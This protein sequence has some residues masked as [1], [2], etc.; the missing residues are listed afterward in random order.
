M[1][2]GSFAR[3]LVVASLV[4]VAGCESLS[5]PA[6]PQV[7]TWLHHPGGALSVVYRRALTQPTRQVGEVYERGQP[8]YAAVVKG[9]GH[10]SFMDIPYLPVE[11]GSM[12]A[13]GL[14]TVRID[15]RRFWR[16]VSDYLLAF[17]GRHL[18]GEAAP[19]L[20]GPSAEHPE[21]VVGA[22]RAGLQA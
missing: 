18:R 1:K 14:A 19:L 11:P 4:P 6:T 12:M 13:A 16:I 5:I 3:L 21:A 20:D 2:L 15:P 9:S 7:P 10:V 22:P 8:G 17:F